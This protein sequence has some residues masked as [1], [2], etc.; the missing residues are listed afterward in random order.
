MHDAYIGGCSENN[1]KCVVHDN[2]SMGSAR[3]GV[4]GWCAIMHHIFELR[5]K[6]K[7]VMKATVR[8]HCNLEKMK[9]EG[10]AVNCVRLTQL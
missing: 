7:K 4:C 1:I 5:V 8:K 2:R 3:P 6:L 9:D 10:I